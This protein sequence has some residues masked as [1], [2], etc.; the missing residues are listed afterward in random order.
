MDISD[1]LFSQKNGVFLV[2]KMRDGK[3]LT[4]FL[5]NRT[6]ITLEVQIENAIG[7]GRSNM[8]KL[9]G[10]GHWHLRPIHAEKPALEDMGGL[11]FSISTVTA[12]LLRLKKL[13]ERE[14]KSTILGIQEMRERW[15][16]DICAQLR[17]ILGENEL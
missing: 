4:T 11:T 2:W 5:R 14:R 12:S 7:D 17:K 6:N 1:L 10:I 9:I 13:P 15:I 8:W 16:P 3:A